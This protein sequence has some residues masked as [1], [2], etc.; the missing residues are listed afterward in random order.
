[1][2]HRTLGKFKKTTCSSILLGV[3]G[4]EHTFLLTF[5]GRS[6]LFLPRNWQ[7]H[8]SLSHVL[9]VKTVFGEQ[10][11]IFLLNA[12]LLITAIAEM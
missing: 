2:N 6:H 7:F 10:T 5:L 11:S 9:K 4:V 1:M 3:G 8:F 12:I